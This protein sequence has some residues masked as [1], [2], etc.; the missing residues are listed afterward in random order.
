MEQDEAFGI[1]MNGEITAVSFGLYAKEEIIAADG[2][3]I[4]ADGLIE[5]A[6][7]NAEGNVR[8]QSDVPF[9]RYY[10]TEV[11]TDPHYMLNGRIYSFE[12]VYA[13]QEVGTVTATLNE[14]KAIEN[15]LI[16]GTI[17]G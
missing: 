11:S 3:K 17:K 12:F 16:R 4:P 15:E 9:G 14:G 10:V 13:G 7:C 5:I 2:S 1:G 8:F 6:F